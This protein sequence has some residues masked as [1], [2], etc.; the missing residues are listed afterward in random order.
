[1]NKN[2]KKILILILLTIPKITFPK[3]LS[4][5]QMQEIENILIHWKHRLKFL[6]EKL[7]DIRC[8]VERRDHLLDKWECQL[9]E[10]EEYLQNLDIC[11]IKYRS[12]TFRFY[13]WLYVTD[14][15]IRRFLNRLKK[16][17]Q[18][19]HCEFCIA[20]VNSKRAWLVEQLNLLESIDNFNWCR[21]AT[22]EGQILCTIETIKNMKSDFDEIIEFHNSMIQLMD[23]VDLRARNLRKTIVD[24]FCELKPNTCCWI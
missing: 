1:M 6:W 21:C 2:L 16:D 5:C 14:H 12:A 22:Q 18:R 9:N 13:R 24:R 3:A 8:V 20:A 15:K 4:R 7:P 19:E 23:Y 11:S 17:S 10:R